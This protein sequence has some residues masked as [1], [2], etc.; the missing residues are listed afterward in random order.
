[1]K[2]TMNYSIIID[3]GANIGEFSL[4]VANR[5]PG[6]KVYAIEPEPT[7]FSN[8]TKATKSLGL[9]NHIPCDFAVS[10]KNGYSDFFVSHHGDW[11]TSSL[12][13]LNS[14]HIQYDDYWSTRTD[15]AHSEIIRVET[16]RLD[17]FLENIKFQ[18]IKFIKIDAQGFDLIALNSLGINLKKVQ[19][20]MIEVVGTANNCLYLNEKNDLRFALN[21]LFNNDFNVYAI[22]PNDNGAKEFNVFFHRNDVDI[23]SIEN[24]LNLEGLINYDGKNFWHY[25]S[26][27]LEDIDFLIHSLKT[28]IHSLK[29]EIH[30]KNS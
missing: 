11:G 23:K 26:Q 2:Y 20:G 17:S 10:D 5:N 22:K 14:N 7:L 29:T 16:K 28:E 4:Q 12:L 3:I 13:Q 1:M 9:L 21:Y 27:K 15:I 18:E 30:K 19:A 24:E 6:I 25:P 8:L